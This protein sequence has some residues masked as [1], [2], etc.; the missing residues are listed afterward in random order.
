[1]VLIE[2]L[3]EEIEFVVTENKK[4][5]YRSISIKIALL[6]SL[7]CHKSVAW[8]K[9]TDF[10]FHFSSTNAMKTLVEE[11]IPVVSGRYEFGSPD[12]SLFLNF[13]KFPTI[14]TS[15]E[16]QKIVS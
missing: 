9:T 11:N 15:W 8:I 4:F 7:D 1:M 5:E 16:D 6:E 12:N 10:L 13:L 2:I 14:K 3:I